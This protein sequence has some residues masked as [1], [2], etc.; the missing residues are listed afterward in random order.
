MSQQPDHNRGGS[1]DEPTRVCLHSLIPHREHLNIP[2]SNVALDVQPVWAENAI[3]L[4]STS[5]EISFDQLRELFYKAQGGVPEELDA[6]KV[7][8][9][10]LPRFSGESQICQMAHQRCPLHHCPGLLVTYRY[11]R[12]M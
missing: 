4:T 2:S 10:L 8:I 1:Q 11:V 9:T 7:S 5:L 6:R 3:N 12:Y